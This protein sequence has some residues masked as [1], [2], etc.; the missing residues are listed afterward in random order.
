MPDLDFAI[1]FKQHRCFTQ[2]WVIIEKQPSAKSLQLMA[3]I[4]SNNLFYN[5]GNHRHR[6]PIGHSRLGLSDVLQQV[7]AV[8]QQ[9]V[10]ALGIQRRL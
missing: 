9:A 8:C 1:H 10:T 4:K 3:K 7:E 5:D 2:W 6:V